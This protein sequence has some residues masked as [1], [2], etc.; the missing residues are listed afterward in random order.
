MTEEMEKMIDLYYEDS[1]ELPENRLLNFKRI[2]NHKCTDR[3]AVKVSIED[4]ETETTIDLGLYFDAKWTFSSPMNERMFW[5]NA[6]ENTEEFK[7]I[8]DRMR[9]P[10]PGKEFLAYRIRFRQLSDRASSKLDKLTT[11]FKDTENGTITDSL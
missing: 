6:K 10:I 11:I 1:I 3:Q 8:F 4:L 9:L 5:K 2:S 7:E